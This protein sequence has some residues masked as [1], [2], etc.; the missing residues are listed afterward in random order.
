MAAGS[1]IHQSNLLER[2]WTHK[3][4][5]P[6]CYVL[7]AAAV[8]GIGIWNDAMSTSMLMSA[9]GPHGDWGPIIYFIGGV[10]GPCVMLRLCRFLEGT[11]ISRILIAMGQNTIPILALHRTIITYYNRIW[12]HFFGHQPE[13]STPQWFLFSVPRLLI[14]AAGSMGLL[15]LGRFL[16]KKYLQRRSAA[17]SH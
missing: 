5:E 11:K 2:Q 17:A 7:A 12:V 6:V 14:A 8:V 13:L 16:K 1:G 3:W 4:L 10:I 15:Y 9:Y